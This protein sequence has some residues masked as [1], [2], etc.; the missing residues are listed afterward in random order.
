MTKG[1]ERIMRKTV[2]LPSIILLEDDSA[3]IPNAVTEVLLPS[4]IL[5]EDDQGSIQ[6]KSWFVLLPSIILLEDDYSMKG[7]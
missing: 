4:I 7:R 6:R 5:L 1:G 2:L 3:V